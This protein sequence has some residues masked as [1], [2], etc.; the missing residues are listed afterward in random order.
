MLETSDVYKR[1]GQW[2]AGT[3]P[4]KKAGI[5][6]RNGRLWQ[7]QHD[8]NETSDE[9]LLS[10]RRRSDRARVRGDFIVGIIV[11]IQLLLH[12]LIRVYMGTGI[13]HLVMAVDSGDIVPHGKGDNCI[14]AVSYT[15][16][17]VYKRQ[18][19]MPCDIALAF[20]IILLRIFR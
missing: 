1:Q 2:R 20:A 10:V 7:Q 9:K 19:F 3:F 6:N 11:G 5:G 18:A 17:D 4:G 8:P 12:F 16:L 15:H 13:I 14:T